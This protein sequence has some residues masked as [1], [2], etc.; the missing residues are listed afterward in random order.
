MIGPITDINPNFANYNKDVIDYNKFKKF[1][2]V[3][4]LFFNFVKVNNFFINQ[5]KLW[6]QSFYLK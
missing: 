1:L 3:R 2:N 6:Y 4:N 5:I